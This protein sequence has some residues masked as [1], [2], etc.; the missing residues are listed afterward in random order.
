MIY[1]QITKALETHL[2]GMSGI[3]AIARQNVIYS[4]TTD[5]AFVRSENIPTLRRRRTLGPTP[6][7]RYEGL[8]R[9]TVCTKEGVG[10]GENFTL[11][12]QLLT[13]FDSSTDLYWDNDTD[14]LYKEDSYELLLESGDPIVLSRLLYLTV[15]YSEAATPFTDSPHFC[16]PINV[17]YYCYWRNA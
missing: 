7:Q 10:V 14:T 12:D 15:D 6:W 2:A 17:H 13:Q 11:V 9:I 8:Y 5:T 1:E 4:P 3:P 16:T